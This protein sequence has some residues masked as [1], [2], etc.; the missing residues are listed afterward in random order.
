MSELT[1]CDVCGPAAER[2]LHRDDGWTCETCLTYMRQL[3]MDKLTLRALLR[4]ERKKIYR[5]RVS[6]TIGEE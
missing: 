1:E 2:D 6:Q 4:L 3:Q 5:E